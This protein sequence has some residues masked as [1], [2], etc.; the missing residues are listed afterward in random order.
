MLNRNTIMISQ[1]Q[2]Q[3]IVDGECTHAS[4][5]SLLQAMESHPSTWRTL[6]LALLEEQQW[7][8]QISLISPKNASGQII[9]AAPYAF[10][11]MESPAVTSARAQPLL[12]VV[13]AEFGQRTGGSN[14]VAAPWLSALAASLLL[15]IGFYGGSILPTAS[16]L[17][18]EV[19]NSTAVVSGL[20]GKSEKLDERQQPNDPM[21]TNMKMLVSGPNRETSVIPIYDL[22]AMDHDLVIAKEMYE[23]ARINQR[24]RREGFELDVRPEYYTGKLNDGRQ[25][26]VPVKHIGLKP[27]GL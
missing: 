16:K 26:I 6:A 13:S 2:I 15:G 21:G 12:S 9:S 8:K 5:A 7:S 24:L 22:D 27:Y 20:N 18:S 23:V 11:E 10:H 3:S 4:R 14:K 25:L 17:K 1:E 19:I